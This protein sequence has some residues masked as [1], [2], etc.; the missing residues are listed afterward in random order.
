MYNVKLR[1]ETVYEVYTDI[2]RIAA[3]NAAA[4]RREAERRLMDKHDRQELVLIEITDICK[5][6]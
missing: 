6:A 3:P 2:L 5:T 1:V 4:A